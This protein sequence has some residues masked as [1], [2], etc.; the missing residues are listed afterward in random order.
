MRLNKCIQYK[1]ETYA[2][3]AQ[4]MFNGNCT[5]KLGNCISLDIKG[6][7]LGKKKRLYGY[8]YLI[9]AALHRLQ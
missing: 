8:L 2:I 1:R 7:V 5:L 4:S 6:G 9:A 3:Y